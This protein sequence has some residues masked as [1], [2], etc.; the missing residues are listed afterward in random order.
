MKEPAL[1]VHQAIIPDGQSPEV[2]QPANRALHDPATAVPAQPASIL[3][4]SPLVV[5]PSRN[6]RLNPAPDEQSPGGMAVIRA[7]GNQSVRPLPG[8]SRSVG[9][10]HRDRIERG[11]EEPDLRRGRRVHVCSQ[12]STRAI[13]QY[14]PRCAL[15]PLGRADCGAPF[16][17][18]AKLPS[19][20]HS[21]PRSFWWSLSWASNARHNARST[22][23]A[24]H[25]R[26]RRH[27]VLGLPYRGGSS[28]HGAPV[29]R[30]HRIPSKHRRASATG[31]PPRGRYFAG[32]R[33]GRIWSHWASVRWRQAMQPPFGKGEHG[34]DS[35]IK[36]Q[37]LKWLLVFLLNLETIFSRGARCR[38]PTTPTTIG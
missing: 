11:F 27:Q 30:I 29:Q 17:A 23:L 36:C 24:S 25:C 12:R 2:P 37:V 38:F 19:M 14:H 18:G 31:R 8:A 26:S 9:A 4:G 22:P 5:G 6:N 32:G 15:T 10:C 34:A 3:V 33:C 1:G 7:V 13:D 35:I 20:K 16:F 28:L 21:F